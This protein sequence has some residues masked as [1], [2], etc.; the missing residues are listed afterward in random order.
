MG[1]LQTKNQVTYIKQKHA[2]ILQNKLYEMF[3]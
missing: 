3:L 2:H 1:L